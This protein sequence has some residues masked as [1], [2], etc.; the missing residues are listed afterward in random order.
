MITRL[1]IQHL[2]SPAMVY[3]GIKQVSKFWAVI[4]CYNLCI[5]KSRSGHTFNAAGIKSAQPKKKLAGSVFELDITQ[6]ESFASS[7]R[8]SLG[9]VWL[10]L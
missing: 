4:L 7:A 10:P 8:T 6:I 1:E 5:V 2:T 9:V 3:S